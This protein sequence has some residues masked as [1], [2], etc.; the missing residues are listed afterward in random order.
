MRPGTKAALMVRITLRVKPGSSR[1]RVGGTYGSGGLVVAVAAPAVDGRATNAAL[2]AV[3]EAF[4]VRRSQVEL[5]HGA[6]SRDKV[7]ALPDVMAS[8]V[9]TATRLRELLAA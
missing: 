8:G 2:R 4:G 5:V 9:P 7:V 3:A 6:T 1:T